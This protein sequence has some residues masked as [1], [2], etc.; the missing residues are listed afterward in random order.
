MR[1]NGPYAFTVFLQAATSPPPFMDIDA[2]VAD[3][4]VVKPIGFGEQRVEA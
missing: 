2:D 1:A 4:A 3:R